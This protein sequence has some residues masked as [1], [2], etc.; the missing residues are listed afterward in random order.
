M[1]LEQDRKS[2]KR[3]TCSDTPREIEDSTAQKI[4]RIS[5]KVAMAVGLIVS[6]VW[7]TAMGKE[8]VREVR[9]M[10]QK[11]CQKITETISRTKPNSTE[12]ENLCS[13]ASVISCLKDPKNIPLTE[14]CTKPEKE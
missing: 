6:V 7:I 10:R 4:E 13:S 14:L 3:T 5:L 9:A 11:T 1:S 12:R 2:P 8:M